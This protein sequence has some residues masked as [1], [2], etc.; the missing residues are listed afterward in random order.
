[1]S[2][3]KKLPFDPLSATARK[4]MAAELAHYM[5]A[6]NIDT[7]FGV[8]K[9]IYLLR[10]LELPERVSIKEALRRLEQQLAVMRE[11][12]NFGRPW[13][14]MQLRKCYWS[15]N[16][17]FIRRPAMPMTPAEWKTYQPTLTAEQIRVLAPWSVARRKA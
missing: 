11:K 13:S 9:A 17:R 7:Q 8:R 3:P 16:T 4:N 2:R 14:Y 5:A 6:L 1:M 12:H 10:V 15:K